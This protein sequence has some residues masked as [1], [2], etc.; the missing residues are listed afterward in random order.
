MLR[1]SGMST[2]LTDLSRRCFRPRGAPDR[3]A[4]TRMV[5]RSPGQALGAMMAR[6][7]PR[8]A[9]HEYG[10]PPISDS[11]DPNPRRAA[12][13][14]RDSSIP[15]YGS[16]ASRTAHGHPLRNRP[17]GKRPSCERHI[18][19]PPIARDLGTDPGR[20]C[21]GLIRSLQFHFGNDEPPVVPLKHVDFPHPPAIA[22]SVPALHHRR[23][24]LQRPE[25]FTRQHGG[26]RRLDFNPAAAVWLAFHGKPRARARQPHTHHAPLFERQVNLADPNPPPS[27]RNSRTAGEKLAFDFDGHA[28][29]LTAPPP[30]GKLAQRSGPALS[31]EVSHET[32]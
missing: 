32:S 18:G 25:Q 6:K 2:G 26:N 22:P 31:L 27:C 4:N 9:D 24:A 29:R 12:I 5:G 8:L 14:D 15:S 28:V 17:A 30:L 20:R 10:L 16:A 13:S 21:H 3:V 1:W 23:T 11:C 7:L 19:E